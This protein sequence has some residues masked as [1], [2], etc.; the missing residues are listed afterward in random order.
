MSFFRFEELKSS[1]Q[2]SNFCAERTF[3]TPFTSKQMKLMCGW[4]EVSYSN[5]VLEN[6]REMSRLV[7]K[8]TM[9]FPTRTDINRPRE[10]QKRARVL[11]FRIYLEEE[12]YCRS[13]ENKGADQLR[14][15]CQ[16]DLRLCF[17]LGRLLVFPCGGS[18]KD[19]FID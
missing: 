3:L 7:G 6:L 14:S 8:P 11:N 1:Y 4:M 10:S 2:A 13:S 15:Y 18:N 17:R 16:A 19:H 9:W 12:L 5:E